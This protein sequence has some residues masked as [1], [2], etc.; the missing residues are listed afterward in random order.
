MIAQRALAIEPEPERRVL[1]VDDNPAIHEDFRKIL[2]DTASSS[3][4]Q[5]LEAKLFGSA[6]KP[7][8]PGP[9]HFLIDVAH[10]GAEGFAKVQRENA[11]GNPY[12]V[13]FVDVRMPPGWDGIETLERIFA[14][15][16]AVQAVLCTA[17]SDHSWS[18]LRERF[19]NTDRLL[20]LRKPYEPIEVVQLAFALSQKW[21]RERQLAKLNEALILSEKRT[22]ALLD[23]VP[24]V[25][26]RIDRDG[27]ILTPGPGVAGQAQTK[28]VPRLDL[29]GT[30]S[31]QEKILGLARESL[32]DGKIRS[33]LVDS[34]RDESG[35]HYHVHIS[36]LDD[37]EV[38]VLLRDVSALRQAERSDAQRRAREMAL[39]MKIDELAKLAT[40]VIPIRE[41]V[42]VMPLVGEMDSR[43]AQRLRET[44]LESLVA[45]R[46]TVIILDLTGLPNLDAIV[47]A[48]LTR[49]AQATRLL[50]ARMVLCG[51]S[52]QAAR[53][54]V[55][56][57]LHFAHVMV[58]RSLE[59]AV[60]WALQR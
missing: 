11:A 49:T 50:G 38:V 7:G 25:L 22:R 20:V 23:A 6:D 12:C 44:M 3:E 54:M 41:G 15:D 17:Y 39:E 21:H 36:P 53:Q 1:V 42:L 35:S 24:D 46:A 48:E 32:K 52:A 56:L 58:V 60:G 26:V 45:Q 47:A 27:N 30:A 16:P 33:E 8:R 18:E 19:G 5:D 2:N 14:L 51:L 40:P 29:L 59:I 43:R 37:L 31:Q 28:V 34:D 55:M 10:Q 9:P 57:D 13:I 4:I